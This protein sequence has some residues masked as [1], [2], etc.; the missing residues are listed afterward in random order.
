M[1]A[2]RRRSGGYRMSVFQHPHR[3]Y[4]TIRTP[5]GAFVVSRGLV[6]APDDVGETLGWRRVDGD[7]PAASPRARTEVFTS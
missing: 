4:G 3:L 2:I 1:P 5:L 7:D 6:E